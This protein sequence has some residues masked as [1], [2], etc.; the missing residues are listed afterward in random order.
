MAP[1]VSIY[2]IKNEVSSVY[3]NL[4]GL[5]RGN[6]LFVIEERSIYKSINNDVISN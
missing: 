5:A 6:L 4:T 2:N 3:S 1:K